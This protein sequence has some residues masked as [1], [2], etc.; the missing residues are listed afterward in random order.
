MFSSASSE[1][2]PIWNSNSAVESSDICETLLTCVA[3]MR[4]EGLQQVT[5]P[6]VAQ[7]PQCLGLDLPSA[8]V[9]QANLGGRHFKRVLNI[10]VQS[11]THPKNRGL[12]R[13]KGAQRL[14]DPLGQC[15]TGCGLEGR[16]SILIG[17]RFT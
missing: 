11:K 17:D 9:S 12:P 15:P 7:L 10:A 8:F 16:C 13:C 1:S 2:A 14:S 4:I 6:R 3:E 5:P